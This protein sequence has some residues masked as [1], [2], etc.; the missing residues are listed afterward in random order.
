MVP[1]QPDTTPD[2]GPQN[3]E[4]MKDKPKRTWKRKVYPSSA[5]RRSVRV[6]QSKKL[7]DEI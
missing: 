4:E 1:L 7:H 3:P 2:T 6:K 5:V